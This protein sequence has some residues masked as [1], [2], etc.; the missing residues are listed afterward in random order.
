MKAEER[1]MRKALKCLYLEAPTSVCEDAELKFNSYKASI[2]KEI[3]VFYDVA[4]DC[5][6]MV[7]SANHQHIEQEAKTKLNKAL[8]ELKSKI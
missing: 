2:I 7:G 1:E 5:I 4:I 3:D 8:Q 6:E